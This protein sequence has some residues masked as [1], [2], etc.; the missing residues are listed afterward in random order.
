MIKNKSRGDN[1]IFFFGLISVLIIIGFW[2]FTYYDLKDLSKEDRGTFGD[3]FGGVNAL[4]S[5]LALVGIIITILLQREDLKSQR[6]ELKLTR[7]EFRKQSY[8]M[9]IQNFESAFFKLITLHNQIV[10]ELDIQLRKSIGTYLQGLRNEGPVTLVTVKGRDVFELLYKD[11]MDSLSKYSN[12]PDQ[13]YRFFYE[14]NNKELSHYFRN[15]YRVYKYLDMEGN[16]TQI[17][18]E[19]S[20]TKEAQENWEKKRDLDVQK[21]KYKYASII[22]AQLSDY[23]LIIIF[24]N[25]IS[26]LGLKF[27]PFIEKYAVLKNLPKHLVIEEHLNLYDTRAYGVADR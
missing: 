18:F 1:S 20:E 21:Q 10:S 6:E 26:E 24:Y 22:R 5:G 8:S 16:I 12:S 17:D 19:E 9:E 25:C 15:L 2:V 23:E 27:K 11:L 4:F 14:S 7:E 13:G 3:M